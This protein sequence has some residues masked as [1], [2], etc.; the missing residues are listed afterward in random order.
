MSDRGLFFPVIARVS[1]RFRTPSVAIWLAAGL[2]VTYVM[3]NTF[4]QLAD[5]FV[6]G[7]WPF[8]ALAVAGVF[9]LRVRQPGLARPYRVWGYP[10]T[11]ALFLLA[12]VGMVVNALVTNP[13]DTGVT[14]GIILAGVPA[15]FLWRGWERRSHG[16]GSGASLRP[17]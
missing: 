14:F 8:Y 5:R 7:V 16:G 17:L 15:Y 1:P 11:P 2:G 3:L 10:V 13:R 4:A 9:I 12:S 6:L